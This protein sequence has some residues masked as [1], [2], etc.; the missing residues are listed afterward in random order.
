MTASEFR[1]LVLERI[2]DP[3]GDSITDTILYSILSHTQRI[4]NAQVEAVMVSL[5]YSASAPVTTLA[6]AS[7]VGFIRVKAASI[8]DRTLI[9]MNWRALA[10]EDPFWTTRTGSPCVWDL[11]SHRLLVLYPAPTTATNVVLEA[12]QD[13][14]P[15]VTGTDTISLPSAHIAALL[16]LTEQVLLLR[17]RVLQPIKGAAEALESNLGQMAYRR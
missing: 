1:T 2:R 5:T 15:I 16:S 7:G 17:Q 6:A 13:L 8:N 11:V 4:L 14:D 3:L 12:V 10:R 9:R